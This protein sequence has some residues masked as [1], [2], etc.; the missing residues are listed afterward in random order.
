[1]WLLKL[2]LSSVELSGVWEIKWN[3]LGTMTCVED[4]IYDICS[5]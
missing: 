2:C 1:M 4:K 5:K 3:E